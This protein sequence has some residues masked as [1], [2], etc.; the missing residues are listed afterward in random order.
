M[1]P[2]QDDKRKCSPIP[3]SCRRKWLSR[4]AIAQWKLYDVECNATADIVYMTAP[5]L[6]TSFSHS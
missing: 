6:F 1:T 5:F 3:R 4:H 2:F